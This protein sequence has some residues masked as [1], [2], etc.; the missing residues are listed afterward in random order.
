MWFVVKNNW[1]AKNSRGIVVSGRM[2]LGYHLYMSFSSTWSV[3]IWY[4]SSSS[5]V[6]TWVTHERFNLFITLIQGTKTTHWW[7]ELFLLDVQKEVL[8]KYSST[9][10]PFFLS[11]CHTRNPAQG[12]FWY[13]PKYVY[14]YFFWNIFIKMCLDCAKK[15]IH[16][17]E[18]YNN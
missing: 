3:L 14:P 7:D 11:F 2:R 9:F 4:W 6:L 13:W 16:V 5:R 12:K 17:H 10:L 15:I 1:L 18:R 8:Q